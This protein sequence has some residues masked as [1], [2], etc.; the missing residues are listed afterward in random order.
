[1]LTDTTYRTTFTIDTAGRVTG[2][3][4][5]IPAGQSTHPTSAATYSTAGTQP[6][7]LLVTSTA[8][9]GGGTNNNYSNAGDL[10]TSTD[11]VGLT[12]TFT[13]DNLGRVA[14][15]DRSAV[16]SGSTVDYGTTAS[17]YNGIGEFA[18]QTLPPVTNPI[19]GVTH[20]QVIT[21][22]YDAM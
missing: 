21:N 6:G 12:T 9:N 18:T 19:T 11:P 22:T 16:V 13:Y 10:L 4:Y 7:G 2:T 20:T 17:T 5:P 8:R 3:S 15:A 14:T 1:S